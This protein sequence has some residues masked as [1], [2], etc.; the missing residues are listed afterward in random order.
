MND[1]FLVVFHPVYFLL[2]S[3]NGTSAHTPTSNVFKV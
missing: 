2:L 1:A 3:L